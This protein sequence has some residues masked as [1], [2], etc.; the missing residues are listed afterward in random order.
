MSKAITAYPTIV[1][2]AIGYVMIAEAASFLLAAL[3]HLGIPL[4]L[5]MTQ[6][7]NLWATLVEGLCGIFAAIGA[8]VVLNQK[9]QAW[10]WAV[11]SHI[12]SALGFLLGII[13]TARAGMPTTDFN[14]IY[15]RVMLTIIV[16]TLIFI[17]MP[18]IRSRQ[19]KQA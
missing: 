10:R 13:V 12:F 17:V 18:Y 19:A 4:P 14:G 2:R 11:G 15:H 3:L 1:P 9:A 7:M 16:I 5:G 6:H 8:Y